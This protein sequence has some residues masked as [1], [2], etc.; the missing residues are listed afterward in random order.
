[1]AAVHRWRRSTDLWEKWVAVI[2]NADLNASILS[3]WYRTAVLLSLDTGSAMVSET[4][5]SSE[6]AGNGKYS[7]MLILTRVGMYPRISCNFL[8]MYS[9]LVWYSDNVSGSCSPLFGS[10]TNSERQ[11]NGCFTHSDEIDSKV[12][13]LFCEALGILFH[14]PCSRMTMSSYFY[15]P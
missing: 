14:I 12:L 7:F 9:M 13:C 3:R 11:R 10:R 5:N 1:M 2:L 8:L 4:S 15:S 6:E